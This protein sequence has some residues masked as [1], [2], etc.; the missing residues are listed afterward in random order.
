MNDTVISSLWAAAI[1]VGTSIIASL[2]KRGETRSAK[3]IEREKIEYQQNAELRAEL[4]SEIKKNEERLAAFETRIADLERKNIELERD[5]ARKDL[6]IEAQ[7][8]EIN[9]LRAELE[10]FERKVYYIPKKE[11]PT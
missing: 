11:D 6:R 1:A 5:N 3:E 9:R 10:K 8:I 2:L 7:E 4:R